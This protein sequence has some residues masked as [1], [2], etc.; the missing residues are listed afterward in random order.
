M[1]NQLLGFV[2]KRDSSPETDERILKGRIDD[3]QILHLQERKNLKKK[4]MNNVRF[5]VYNFY[6]YE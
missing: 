2:S 5:Y 3:S 1:S 6:H 4:K